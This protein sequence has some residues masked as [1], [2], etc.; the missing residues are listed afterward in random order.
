MQSAVVCKLNIMDISVLNYDDEE[1]DVQ[2][3]IATINANDRSIIEITSPSLK[4]NRHYNTTLNV[5]NSAGSKTLN[6]IL[7]R[8]WFY[9]ELKSFFN[10]FTSLQVLMMFN[11]LIWK[12]QQSIY[13]MSRTPKPKEHSVS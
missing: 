9:D 10:S 11:A 12:I 2:D 1:I 3:M 7:S 5:S 6:L 8:L 4:L 13:I